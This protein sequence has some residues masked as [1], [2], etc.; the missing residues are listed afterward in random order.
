MTT[1]TDWLLSQS[2]ERQAASL[3]HGL[4]CVQLGEAQRRAPFSDETKELTAKVRA[5]YDRWR[6]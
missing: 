5:Y 1:Y 6:E 2:P 4:I 3:E